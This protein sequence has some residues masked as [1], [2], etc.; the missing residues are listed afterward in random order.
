MNIR[1]IC[2]LATWVFAVRS[3]I[4]TTVLASATVAVVLVTVAGLVLLQSSAATQSTSSWQTVRSDV[5]IHGAP[6]F[7]GAC[8]ATGASCPPGDNLSIVVQL[9]RYNGI[10]YYDYSHQVTGGSGNSTVTS[11]DATGG[12]RVSTITGELTTLA[13]TAWFTNTTLYCTTPSLNGEVIACP[14]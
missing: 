13:Y 3:G 7:L 10:Y 5:T 4:S 9:I 2:A 1:D 14:S 12:I 11:T 8:A 6:A